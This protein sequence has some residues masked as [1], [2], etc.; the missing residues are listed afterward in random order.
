MDMSIIHQSSQSKTIRALGLC[1]GGLDSILS[2]L[3]LKKQGID[4]QWICFETP[5]FNAE[6]AKEASILTQIPLIVKNITEIY[7]E[8]LKNP[9]Q[10]YGKYMN[11]CMDCHV[12]MLKCAG[13][14]MSDMGAMFLFS[15]E[16]LGQ[17][18]K[19]QTRNALKYVDKHSGYRGYILRPLSAKHMEITIPEE[20]G[21][22]KREKLMD[23]TGRGRKA[24]ISL[25]QQFGITEYPTP[26]GGC[27]LTDFQ[28]ATRLKDLFDNGSHF[29]SRDLYLLKWGRHFRLNDNDKI[30]VGRTEA[31]NEQIQRYYRKDQDILLET[32]DIPGPSTLIPYGCDSDTLEIAAQISIS[33]TKAPAT[34]F[35]T[36]QCFTPKGMSTIQAKPVS[37]N[38]SK[39]WMITS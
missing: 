28:Y 31:E 8:M 36:V 16:V 13:Q 4:V 35:T 39:K 37:K 33:Y 34:A 27:L 3:L 38:I 23:I 20:N 24:Q 10:G 18:P 32:P 17:R 1:S 12:L 5:F 26:A 7:L 14:L 29:E 25:A 22:V 2:G 6:K 15:G 11:P 30:I 21:W 19:S 9:N